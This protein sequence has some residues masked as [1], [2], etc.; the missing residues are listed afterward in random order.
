MAGK[1][2]V[3]AWVDCCQKKYIVTIITCKLSF[4]LLHCRVNGVLAVSRAFGDISFK[5]QGAQKGIVVSE[6]DVYT[7]VITPMTEF[8]IIA[9]DGLWD[10]TS[11]QA[12]VNMV[13]KC[14]SKEGDLKQAA[15]ELCDAAITKGSV[16]NITA[17]IISF[18]MGGKS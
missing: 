4:L 2:L 11:P 3:V 9:T 18:N 7:E 12:A 14:L 8:A 6:P 13:R 5:D 1:L 10:V 15:K 17:L 16:D